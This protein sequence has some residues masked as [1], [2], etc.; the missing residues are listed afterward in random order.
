MFG[1][2]SH[3]KELG[4]SFQKICIEYIAFKY[5]I[6][7]IKGWNPNRQF[8]LL[9]ERETSIREKSSHYLSH[10]RTTEPDGAYFD[11]FRLTMSKPTR[12][13][14]SFTPFRKQQI[15]YQESPFFTIPGSFQEKTR[16]QRG[17][18]D[19][20]QPQ[21]ERVRPNDPAASGIGET[22]TQKPEIA[23]NTSIISSPIER[24]ITPTQNEENVVTP[25][26]NLNSDQLWLQMSQFSVQ[27]QEKFDKLYRRNIRLQELT[28]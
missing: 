27:T 21:E 7:I 18:Q 17:K 1:L 8:K 14:S 5:L 12:I 6:L 13:P 16:I 4:E 28:I 19:F 2:E 26:S 25:E 3:W 24:N 11:S 22:I 23:V 20:F 10:R 9:E 15:S